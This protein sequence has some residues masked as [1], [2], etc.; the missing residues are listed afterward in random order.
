MRLHAEGYDIALHFR[1]SATE[2]AILQDELER[3]RHNSTTLL[4]AEL[5]ET[6]ELPRLVERVMLRF[7][8]LDVLVNNASSF[9]PTP[10]GKITEAVWDTLMAVNVKAPLFLSQAAAFHLRQTRGAIVNL[11]DIYAERPLA[12]HSV[13]NISKAALQMLTLSLAQELAPEVRVNAIAPGAILWPE[14]DDDPDRQKELLART[15]LQRIGTAEEIA[16]AVVFLARDAGYTT[17]Q[18]L[19]V[20]GGRWLAI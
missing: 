9:F 6:D 12:Q 16:R 3:R 2:A 17:G 20:D 10:I 18:V 19:R 7:G 13:Y 11:V 8:R 4:R 14:A 5:L 1:D 15:P